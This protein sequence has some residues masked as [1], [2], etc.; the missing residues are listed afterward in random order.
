MNESEWDNPDFPFTATEEE[1]GSLTFTW[2]ENH[3]A[4]CVFN[5]WTEDD[6]IQMLRNAAESTLEQSELN[7]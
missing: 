6:F 2:D 4:T 3:P 7:Q 1:D 5:D